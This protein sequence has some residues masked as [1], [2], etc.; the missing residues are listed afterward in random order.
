MVAAIAARELW[1]KLQ[2]EAGLELRLKSGRRGR[3]ADLEDAVK[4]SLL[5][6]VPIPAARDK[7][8]RALLLKDEKSKPSQITTEKLLVAVLTSQRGFAA[9]MEDILNTLIDADA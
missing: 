6:Q 3:D 7:S 2:L 1:D 5:A 8:L 9:M 4:A